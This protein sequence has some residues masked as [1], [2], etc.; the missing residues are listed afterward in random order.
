M[1]RRLGNKTVRDVTKEVIKHERGGRD[2]HSTCQRVATKLSALPDIQFCTLEVFLELLH[3]LCI[4]EADTRW[5]HAALSTVIGPNLYH[6]N[7]EDTE[8]DVHAF[9]T[10]A[11]NTVAF[12]IGHFPHIFHPPHETEETELVQT[13]EAPKKPARKKRSLP[14]PGVGT[15]SVS[16]VD[17]TASKAYAETMKEMGRKLTSSSEHVPSPAESDPQVRSRYHL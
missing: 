17:Q 12:L 11:N 2:T 8:T 5:S 7:A 3:T 1:V 6:M 4:H 15:T 9:T 16:A 14:Q 10:E 13:T